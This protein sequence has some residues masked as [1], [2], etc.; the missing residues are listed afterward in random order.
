M[1]MKRENYPFSNA[2]FTMQKTEQKNQSLRSETNGPISRL[3]ISMPRHSPSTQLS[4]RMKRLLRKRRDILLTLL[5]SPNGSSVDSRP[6]EKNNCYCDPP[7]NAGSNLI[8][9]KTFVSIFMLYP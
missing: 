1:L 5:N 2:W 3:K 8:S 4:A 6:L 9:F 7:E